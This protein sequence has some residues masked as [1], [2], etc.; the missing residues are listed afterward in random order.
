M[1]FVC[2]ALAASY[3]LH[4]AA[5]QHCQCFVVHAAHATHG[6]FDSAQRAT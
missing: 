4:A 1:S 3:Q 5:G 6:V 2:T